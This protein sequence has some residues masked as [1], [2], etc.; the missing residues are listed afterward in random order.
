MFPFLPEILPYAL[1]VS[2]MWYV[3]YEEWTGNE[4]GKKNMTLK[5]LV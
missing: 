2:S 5:F 1:S 4:P 3:A